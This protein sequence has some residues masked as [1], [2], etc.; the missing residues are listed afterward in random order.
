[1]ADEAALGF[2]SGV[3]KTDHN[4][5]P[6][7]DILVTMPNTSERHEITSRGNAKEAEIAQETKDLI[8]KT[9]RLSAIAGAK[10]AAHRNQE[11]NDPSG[12]RKSTP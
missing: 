5:K 4:A 9:K 2:V 1:M 10:N 3:Y 8:V 7:W 11:Q 12:K 6:K